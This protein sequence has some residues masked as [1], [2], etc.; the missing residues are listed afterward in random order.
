M[1]RM[2]FTWLVFPVLVSAQTQECPKGFQPFANRCIT[3][4]MADYISCVEATGGNRLAISEELTQLGSTQAGAGVKGQ[5]KG[6][7][8][9]GSGAIVLDK[10]SENALVKKLENKWFPGGTSECA[11]VLSEGTATKKSEADPLPARSEYEK[12]FLTTQRQFVDLNTS[13]FEPQ[14]AS[15]VG[16]DLLFD[17][18]LQLETAMRIL[19]YP[20]KMPRAGLLTRDEWNELRATLDRFGLVLSEAYK[21]KGIFEV[22]SEKTKLKWVATIKEIADPITKNLQGNRNIKV[23]LG[24]K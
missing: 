16:T 8:V 4:R 20:V 14:M 12:R 9:Q 3:Q 6:V 22:S 10:K 24:N 15:S 17:L 21:S 1:R 11:K 19:E 18:Q 2:L 13:F 23:V 5:A 7:V